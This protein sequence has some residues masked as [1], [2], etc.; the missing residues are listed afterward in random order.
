M[1]RSFGTAKNM[2]NSDMKIFIVGS[3][4][5]GT[6]LA[7]NLSKDGCEVTLIDTDG[8]FHRCHWIQG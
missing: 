3:G 8:K 7:S 5:I 2:K 4:S 1:I 6:S